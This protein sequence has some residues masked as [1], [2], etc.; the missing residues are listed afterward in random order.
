M[1][2]MSCFLLT[3]DI[4]L[5]D[6]PIY[7]TYLSIGATYPTVDVIVVTCKCHKSKLVLPQFK[8]Q[9][10]WWRTQ[11]WPWCRL[12]IFYSWQMYLGFKNPKWCWLL[13]MILLNR[14]CHKLLFVTEL[15]SS[16]GKIPLAFC[17][18]IPMAI[19]SKHDK[20]AIVNKF[21]PCYSNYVLC[22]DA[23]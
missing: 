17:R 6:S 23:P 7:P 9:C 5:H 8:S 4:Y 20:V 12:P 15:I 16:S 22:Y 11:P 2:K 18:A 21:T 3:I 14:K 10:W 19:Y 13:K 1:C